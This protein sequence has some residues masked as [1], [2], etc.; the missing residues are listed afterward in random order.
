M[1]SKT[2]TRVDSVLPADRMRSLRSLTLPANIHSVSIERAVVWRNLQFEALEHFV[3]VRTDQQHNLRGEVVGVNAKGQPL[4]V[5]YVIC[6][7]LEWRTELVVVSQFNG[8]GS[9]TT[10]QIRVEGGRWAHHGPSNHE[11]LPELD[12]CIDIDL[13]ITPATNTLPI[14]RLNL[15]IGQS[16]E[17]KAAWI[18]FPEL[19]IAPLQQTYT[20]V[21]NF[22]YRYKSA[23]G[24]TADLE[25]DDLGLV[26][27][28]PGGWQRLA[29]S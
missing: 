1:Q 6:C 26:I 13:G 10:R 27:N 4:R 24:F 28:Y 8:A 16:A 25:V 20:R 17:V 3:L 9:P 7:S 12:G 2:Q 21:S 11:A 18:K 14:R 15:R 29:S 19:T 22:T 5:N 23:S